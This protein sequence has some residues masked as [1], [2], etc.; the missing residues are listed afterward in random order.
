MRE[1]RG[2]E[3]TH[4]KLSNLEVSPDAQA[5]VSNDLTDGHPLVVCTDSCVL[6]VRE[7]CARRAEFAPCR[8]CVVRV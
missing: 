8:S 6:A 5:V 2:T 3:E 4:Q 7:A 1:E